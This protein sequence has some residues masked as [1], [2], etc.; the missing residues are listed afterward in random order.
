MN[1]GKV[2]LNLVKLYPIPEILVDKEAV[3]EG[4]FKILI[5]PTSLSEQFVRLYLRKLMTQKRLETDQ[6]LEKH[7]SGYFLPSKWATY[8]RSAKGA[9][10]PSLLRELSSRSTLYIHGLG[11]FTV[12]KSRTSYDYSPSKVGVLDHAY[13]T[14]FPGQLKVDL[15]N[16]QE[17]LIDMKKGH[18]VSDKLQIRVSLRHTVGRDTVPLVLKP[19]QENRLKIGDLSHLKWHVAQEIRDVK[20]N[21]LIRIYPIG[22]LTIHVNIYVGSRPGL[23][24]DDIITLGKL[25]HQYIKLRFHNSIFSIDEF[26]ERIYETVAGRILKP[27]KVRPQRALGHTLVELVEPFRPLG[28]LLRNRTHRQEIF[29][30]VSMLEDWRRASSQRVRQVLEHRYDFGGTTA[31]PGKTATLVIHEK[32]MRKRRRRR[33][34]LEI[35]DIVE[36]EQ[37]R[38]MMA[39]ELLVHIRQSNDEIISATANAWVRLKKI[40]KISPPANIDALLTGR[41]IAR[42]IDMRGYDSFRRLVD[43]GIALDDVMNSFEKEL[44]RAT[45]LILAWKPALKSILESVPYFK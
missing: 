40:A 2:Y 31:F 30:I 13:E 1:F 19:S 38:K 8:L 5:D 24:A 36:I 20:T 6:S 42:G 12:P 11:E 23:N 44:D 9:L 14:V 41:V 15:G 27:G 29:G 33:I 34:R 43:E 18:P 16:E 39:K 37:V 4:P 28:A 3:A 10:V 45:E 17:A 21:F 7:L 25:G 35:R 26:F 22:A 32:S